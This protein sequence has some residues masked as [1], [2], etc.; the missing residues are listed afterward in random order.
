MKTKLNYPRK[1][2]ADG[3]TKYGDMF[4]WKNQGQVFE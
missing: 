4:T 3:V 2:C 1:R